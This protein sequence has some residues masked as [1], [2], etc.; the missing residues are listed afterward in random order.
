M[1]ALRIPLLPHR[2]V[3]R[4]EHTAPTHV[5]LM[6]SESGKSIN[7]P[8]VNSPAAYCVDCSW[9]I[10]AALGLN[11]ALLCQLSTLG[12]AVICNSVS[13]WWLD[14]PLLAR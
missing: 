8:A 1:W 5:L 4:E 3:E 7:V 11:A 6:T 9:Q 10:I 2:Q 14:R 13:F 12:S